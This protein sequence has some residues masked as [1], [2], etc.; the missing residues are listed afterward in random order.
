LITLAEYLGFIFS[1]ITRARGS[2]DRVSAAI[3][4][5]YAADPIMQHFSVPRF[6]I[7]EMTVTVPML[8]SGAKFSS[9]LKLNAEPAEFADFVNVEVGGAML[10]V[11]NARPDAPRG[12][13]KLINEMFSRAA[14]ASVRSKSTTKTSEST[15]PVPSDVSEFYDLVVSKL[16]AGQAD[17]VVAAKYPDIFRTRFEA[18]RLGD[19]YKKLF[20][21]DE[22]LVDSLARV[23]SF[24]TAHTVVDRVRMENLL[25]NPE[26]NVIKTLG[27]EFSVFTVTAKISEEGVFVK[28]IKDDRGKTTSAAVEFE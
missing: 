2:A 26:T 22:L 17:S 5:A 6:K 20:P 25:V 3:A 9:V 18:K 12:N 11:H 1:E 28:S 14:S 15:G 7:P 10:K 21:K 8:I 16:N 24:V 4:E 27:N 13:A 19:E 23:Q